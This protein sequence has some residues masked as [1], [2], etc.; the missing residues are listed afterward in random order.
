MT[1]S[2]N[3]ADILIDPDSDVV[4]EET[5]Y[6]ISFKPMVPLYFGDYIEITVPPQ[7]QSYVGRSLDYCLGIENVEE[8]LSCYAIS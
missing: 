1:S 4:G 7:I 5:D 6:Y 3:L 8:D 2:V